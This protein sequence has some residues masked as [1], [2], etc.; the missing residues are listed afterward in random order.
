VIDGGSTD[1]TLKIL[2]NYKEGIDVLITE[3][4]NGL[5]HAV[6]KGL[7]HATGDYIGWLN[8]DDLYQPGALNKVN[9]FLQQ[10][11]GADLV[12]GEAAHIDAEGRFMNFHNACPFDKDKLLHQ[13]CYIA[14]QAT[15]FRRSCLSYVGLLDTSLSW[16]MDWDM[17]KRF[18]VKGLQIQFI[19]NERLGDWRIHDNSLSYTISGS[20]QRRRAV[21]TFKS[22]R[23]YSNKMISPI[24]IRL[25]PWI[26]L[27]Y[28]G[29]YQPLRN[30]W[31]A[32]KRLSVV[33][34]SV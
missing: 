29:L 27:Y 7:L 11:R 32:W 8:A 28:L 20:V 14:S 34:S 18:A 13:R 4:D 33:I 24:E 31:H 3:P 25:L 19:P 6:N 15:F 1:K 17:W 12:Y 5:S 10:N 2:E 22:A 9:D 21:E 23:K 26:A 16:N 30:I